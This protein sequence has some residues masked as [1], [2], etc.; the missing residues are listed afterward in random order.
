MEGWL[1]SNTGR[2]D[3][4]LLAGKTIAIVG[5]GPAGLTLA[6]LL[7]M[8]GVSVTV[9]ER[10]ASPHARLQGGSL[11]LHEDGGQLALN[12][13]GLLG[14]FDAVS[15][16]EGQ[17]TAVVDKH[18]ARLAGWSAADE[19][20]TKPEIDR[21]VLRDL[22]L[23]SLT[24][25]TVKWDSALSAIERDEA[26]RHRLMFSDG[27]TAVADLVV[28]ADGSRSKV[29]QAITSI[30]SFYTGVT[31]IEAR[32]SDVDIREPE[33]AEYVGPGHVLAL[34]DN[35]GLLA[36]RNG[37]GSIRIYIAR[38]VPEDWA[39]TNAI[40]AN[41]APITRERL[42]AWFTDW[43]PFL[44]DMVRRSDD[45]FLLWPL[46]AFPADQTWDT[47]PGLTIIGDAAHVMPPF[48]GEGANMAMLDAVELAD[49]LLSQEFQT[50]ELALTAFERSMR[51]RMAP[52]IRGSVETQDLLFAADA[53]AGLVA[54]FNVEAE[55]Q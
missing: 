47:K 4:G 39:T 5:A 15:R 9:F 16:P 17:S 28:G 27:R 11:D 23:G 40:D 3:L 7:Q 2:N 43:A 52:L 45:R 30:A 46:H 24:D 13:C 8:N 42:L 49:H 35:K 10:D 51:G 33:I 6:K 12:R 29:R 31:F 25:G 34:S 22:L 32:L 48:L 53:P 41:D 18:G 26:G 36:Q 55:S 1:M 14:R 20:E 54:T 19:S 44:V 37:D 21:G 50:L 38:R